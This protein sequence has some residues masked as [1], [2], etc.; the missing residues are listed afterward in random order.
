MC[1]LFRDPKLNECHTDFLETNYEK[2]SPNNDSEGIKL[3][4]VTPKQDEG[5]ADLLEKYYEIS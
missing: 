2:V 3:R 4:A 1:S 5:D